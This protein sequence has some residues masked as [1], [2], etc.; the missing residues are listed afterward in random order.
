[1]V[2]PTGEVTGERSSLRSYS[3]GVRPVLLRD[4]GT[5]VIIHPSHSTDLRTR[6]KGLRRPQGSG[7]PQ[8]EV[9]QGSRSPHLLRRTRGRTT[10]VGL[11]QTRFSR[12]LHWNWRILGCNISTSLTPGPSSSPVCRSVTSSPDLETEHG[13]GTPTPVSRPDPIGISLVRCVTPSSPVVGR[14]VTT[15]T[16]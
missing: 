15:S 13:R 12:G 8:D 4:T 16:L 1:M 2:S 6:R 7:Y 11:L 14:E 3:E 9:P 10:T 5:C